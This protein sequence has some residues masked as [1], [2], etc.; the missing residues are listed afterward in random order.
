MSK[1]TF[2][3]CEKP[4]LVCM[5]QADN[6]ARIKELI[7]RSLPEGAEAFG[8]Q[9]CKMKEEYRNESTYRELFAY[10]DK[11]IYVTNYRRHGENANRSD[12]EIAAGLL[13]LAA[14]GATLCDVMGDFFDPCEG[15]LTMNEEAIQKQMALIDALHARGVEVL[16]SSHVLKF[17]PAERVLE[18]AL[19]HQKRGADICKIVTGAENMAQQ[20]EN[21][22]IITLLKENLKIPFLFLTG[23]ECHI[24]R[25]LGG[26]LGNC[27][28]LCV[29]EHDEL[30]TP[31]QPLLCDMK[32]I[33][34][35]I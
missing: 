12:E 7:D 6:P 29:Y 15:E 13:E 23:G 31:S 34:D 18:I 27:M 16:M 26:T 9:F 10:T 11:P 24:S 22:R 5:V 30:A 17:T 14:C 3:N 32:I 21:L 20:I 1:R 28:S 25:R 19:E 4:L 8:M 35:L 2:L 33:R